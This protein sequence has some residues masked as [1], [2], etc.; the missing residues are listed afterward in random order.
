MRKKQR[1]IVF[2]S[3]LTGLL[4]VSSGCG[5][6]TE[7]TNNEIDPPKE[8]NYLDKGESLDE[9]GKDTDAMAGGKD[10]PA[11][12]T[13]SQ[14]LQVYLINENGLVVPQTMNLPLSQEPAKQVV[15]YLVRDGK[16]SN[17]LPNGM[18]AVLP[19]GTEVLDVNIDQGTAVVDFSEDFKE[20]AVE[21]EQRILQSLTYTL[22]QFDNI[23][24]VKIRIN[25]IDQKVMPVNQTPIG[26]SMTRADGINIETNGVVD[27]TGSDTVTV[28][29]VG[30]SDGKYQYVP[31]TRVVSSKDNLVKSTVNELLNGPSLQSGLLSD[32]RNT[33]ELVSA[34][35]E[36][37]GVV[38]L[39][40]NEAILS[41]LDN[42]AISNVVLNSLVLSITELTGVEKVS[43][44]VNGEA[45]V[46]TE[47]GKKLTEPVSRPVEVNTVEF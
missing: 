19:A 4:I 39:N 6:L 41:E 1:R 27:I 14:Q 8:V 25:G 16:V 29:F 18:R 31:V 11:G 21:D 47:V 17:M 35:V 2:V 10:A 23:S 33:V 43:I 42:T 46:L 3:L 28:Y 12:A 20:Y 40:F 32:F 34:P 7:K 22:T 38:T 44:K 9:N 5:L 36:E 30:A 26:E 37:N 15:E 24:A 13:D 45:E